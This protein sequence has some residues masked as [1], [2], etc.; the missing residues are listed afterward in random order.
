MGFSQDFWL[1]MYQ[2]MMILI[3]IASLK[4]ISCPIFKEMGQNK[5]KGFRQPLSTILFDDPPP[6]PN[7]TPWFHLI[8]TIEAFGAVY[9]AKKKL[10]FKKS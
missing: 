2:E 5:I 7:Y 8:Y 10:C 9:W 1:N 3:Y 4:Q 6:Y